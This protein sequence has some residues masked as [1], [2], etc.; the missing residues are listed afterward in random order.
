[1]SYCKSCSGAINVSEKFCLQCG[2]PLKPAENLFQN[3]I[4]DSDNVP[5][6][7]LGLLLPGIGIL[8]ALFCKTCN[9]RK[10]EKMIIG[11]II[12]GFAVI[13]I[14]SMLTSSNSP[15]LLSDETEVE[16]VYDDAYKIEESAA[17]YCSIYTCE[18]NEQ[19]YWSQLETFMEL[20]DEDMYNCTLA[21]QVVAI[22][23]TAGIG[24]F[25]E[26]RGN[27]NWEFQMGAIPSETGID[28]VLRDNN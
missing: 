27:D 18:N 21:N 3:E 11:S 20:S 16:L 23:T 19:L 9:F 17:I 26:R 28:H 7:L 6:F 4:M 25:L 5:P 15:Y 1:M 10:V 22:K 24:V 12:S 8:F 14:I 13:I 2:A